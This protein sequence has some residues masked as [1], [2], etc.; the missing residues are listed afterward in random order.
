MADIHTKE[1]NR[2]VDNR[3]RVTCLL[4]QSV[5]DLC[6]AR[7]SDGTGLEIDGILCVT[8][9][10]D[11]SEN[12]VIIKVHEKISAGLEAEKVNRSSDNDDSQCLGCTPVESH[13]SNDDVISSANTVKQESGQQYLRH[14][15]HLRRHSLPPAEDVS[16]DDEAVDTVNIKGELCGSEPCPPPTVTAANKKQRY[17]CDT[18]NKMFAQRSAL[19]RHSRTH[20]GERPFDCSECESKFGDITTL[21][22]H[23]ASL[24]NLPPGRER[25]PQPIPCEICGKVLRTKYSLKH[26][27]R[28][29]HQGIK[30]YPKKCLCTLCGKICRN[31]TV[32]KEHQ[33]KWHLHI[34]PYMCKTCGRP[35]HAKGLLRAHEKQTHSDIRNYPCEVC[36]KAFKRHNA[37][38]EHLM[39][40][41]KVRPNECDICRKRFLQKAGLVRHYRTHTGLRPFQCK[42]CHACFAD[43]STLRRHVIAVHNVPHDKWNKDDFEMIAEKPDKTNVLP[44]GRRRRQSKVNVQDTLCSQDQ[45]SAPVETAVV[46]IGQTESTG[47]AD[48]SVAND[49]ATNTRSDTP[50]SVPQPTAAG[51]DVAGDDAV[52]HSISATVAGGILESPTDIDIKHITDGQSSENV[53]T[54]VESKGNSLITWDSDMMSLSQEVYVILNDPVVQPAEEL[55]TT[56]KS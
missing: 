8:I 4:K 23:M 19:V 21:R 1:E 51:T 42:V 7:L 6:R 31:V 44:R 12:H 24:H 30:T 54:L 13:D 38:K 17:I 27:I 26:H 33:N 5:I 50:V 48:D 10:D 46:M 25:K 37:L 28:A 47:Q 2:M 9:G 11:D 22:R 15:M 40:H 53:I 29:V 55:V 3:K 14:S 20:T 16:V 41:T 35:F 36:G 45:P 34:K 39:T 43:A 18:C 52:E 49:I 56:Q 32:L